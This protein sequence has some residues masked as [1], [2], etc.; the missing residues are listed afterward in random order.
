MSD[1]DETSGTKSIVFKLRPME[2]ATDINF[3]KSVLWNVHSMNNK[4]ADV[5][6]DILDRQSYVVFLN[7]TWL[8]SENRLCCIT[9]EIKSYGYQLLHNVTKDERK[10]RKKDQGKG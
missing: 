4:L 7:E 8:Q 3:I 5:M 9:T 10:D 2:S 6:E 1:N